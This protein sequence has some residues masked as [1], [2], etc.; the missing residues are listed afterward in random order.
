MSRDVYIS[1]TDSPPAVI[2]VGTTCYRLVGP[3][4]LEPN[5]DSFVAFGDCTTC[6]AAPCSCPDGLP[7]SYVISFSAVTWTDSRFDAVVVFPA[8]SVTATGGGCIW[9]ANATNVTVN[10]VLVGGSTEVNLYLTTECDECCWEIYFYYDGEGSFGNSLGMV[11]DRYTG[12]TP[13]GIFEYT[14][15]PC[16]VLYFTTDVSGTAV[17]SLT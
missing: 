1:P 3:S 13:E 4:L 17:V 8:Q 2:Q 9:L 12:Q 15:E 5:V 10:G 14:T 11:M 16:T 6:M 7:S